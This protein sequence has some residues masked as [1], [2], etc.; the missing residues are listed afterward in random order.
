MTGTLGQVDGE[1]PRER[2][3][4][5]EEESGKLARAD[6]TCAELL[7]PLC[8]YCLLC[9]RV[10]ECLKGLTRCEISVLCLLVLEVK[11]ILYHGGDSWVKVQ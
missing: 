10:L 1:A 3:Q 11:Y 4:G 7:D 9:V 8:R 6:R 2:K 5:Y